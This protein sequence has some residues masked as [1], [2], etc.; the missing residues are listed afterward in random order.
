MITGVRSVPSGRLVVITGPSERIWKCGG[1]QH[2]SLQ[3]FILGVRILE[4]GY[5]RQVLARRK[6][7]R[8][9]HLK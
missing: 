6:C 8:G 5:F 1:G 9:G 4:K 2:G 3:G 7:Q